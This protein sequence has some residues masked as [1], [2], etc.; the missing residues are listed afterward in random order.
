MRTLLV[1]AVGMTCTEEVLKRLLVRLY[2]ILPV[3]CPALILQKVAERSMD[4][5]N[6][7]GQ[8]STAGRCKSSVLIERAIQD[9]VGR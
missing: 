4:D 1:R 9:R 6:P 2:R 5:S 7:K 3:S 8:V